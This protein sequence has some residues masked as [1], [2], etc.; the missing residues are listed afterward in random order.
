MTGTIYFIQGENGPIKIGHTTGKPMTRLK[1]LQTGHPH[2]LTLLA[3]A[4]G[5]KQMEKALHLRFRQYQLEGEWFKPSQELLDYIYPVIN[6]RPVGF[7][8]SGIRL[9]T[10]LQTLLDSIEKAYVLAALDKA[11]GS[12]THAAVLLG[13]SFRSMRYRI[14]KFNIE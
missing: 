11:D 14:D 13:V 5:T 10:D 9:P 6:M 8:I 3:T 7:Q 4:P 2:K 1:S 12:K